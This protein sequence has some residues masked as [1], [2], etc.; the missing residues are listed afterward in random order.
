MFDNPKPKVKL[1]KK[2]GG[3]Q[4][5]VVEDTSFREYTV[6]IKLKDAM[7]KKRWVSLTDSKYIMEEMLARLLLGKD[8]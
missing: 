3:Y 2:I 6:E 4:V 1:E 8:K 5:R 7:G